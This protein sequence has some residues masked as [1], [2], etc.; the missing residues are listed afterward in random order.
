VAHESL[1]GVA[2]EAATAGAEAIR[3]VA[4]A[5]LETREKSG[6]HDVVTAADLAAERAVLAVLAERRPH[7]SVVAEE[8]GDHDGT[9]D[10]RWFVDPLD[11]T[12][13]FVAGS[14]HYSVSVAAYRDGEALAAV[15]YRPADGRWI[16][17]HDDGGLRT[18]LP[19]G[20]IG[21][22]PARSLA[23]SRLNVSRP[24]EQARGAAA[25]ALRAAVIP[26]IAEEFRSGAATYGLWLVATGGL[27][28]YISVDIPLWDTAAGHAIVRLAGGAVRTVS[29]ASG[30]PATVTGHPVTVD[31][32]CALI[33]EIG[34]SR[35][36]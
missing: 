21:V 15:L 7:D 17:T 11:G 8:S 31:R 36:V 20:A 24:H 6:A 34:V 19:A 29:L 13:N 32:L 26:H 4:A 16:A 30:F 28:A 18:N 10:V 14:P 2:L 3:A 1:H 35:P 27:D 23:Q 12:G 5:D 9:S 25:E 33:E 22:G